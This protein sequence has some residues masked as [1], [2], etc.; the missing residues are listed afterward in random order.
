LLY[1][2]K[3]ILFPLSFLL[4][5]V[6]NPINNN[7]TVLLLSCLQISI[8]IKREERRVAFASPKETTFSILLLLSYLLVL[9]RNKY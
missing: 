8:P 3:K 5:V 4:L 6:S 7:K 1:F 2:F 9:V